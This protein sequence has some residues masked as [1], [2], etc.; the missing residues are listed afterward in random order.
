MNAPTLAIRGRLARSVYAEREDKNV[1]APDQFALGLVARVRRAGH[2]AR[3]AARCKRLARRAAGAGR[4]RCARWATNTLRA[5]AA[6]GRR[7][8]RAHAWPPRALQRGAA[9]GGRGRA[10]H[11]GHAALCQRSWSARPRC[12][13]AAW[14]RC[15]PARARP[16]RRHRRLPGRAW[17]ACRCTWSPSTTT[18]R[19]ATPTSWRR[20]SRF[21][22]LSVGVVVADLDAAGQARRP[23]PA[24]SPTAPT[25]TWSST[26]CAT[27]SPPAAAPAPAQLRARQLFDRR[28]AHAA[29]AAR[30]ALRHRRRGRQHP[31]R[32][33]AHAADP[34]RKGR[35]Q[36]RMPAR[37][38]AG[39]GTGPASSRR[40]SDYLHRRRAPRAAPDATPAA[41]RLAALCAGRGD[42]WR[43]AHAREHLL[44]QALRAL[45]L[46]QRDKQY[47]VAP[48]ARCRSS[49][50]T[51]A[52]CC[53]TAPGSRACTR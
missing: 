4:T 24:T 7:A 1:T 11:A 47:L 34:G 19:G 21:A 3:G 27:A 50:N 31:H 41:Q 12:C 52:A 33:G 22:G 44:L 9:A 29:A 40:R 38:A 51:P 2:A 10:A 5:G 14:P 6:P 36:A 32:R 39:A 26:T 13:A 45:H 35:R 42:P 48:T 46:F 53:P 16:H 15:R 43:S 20:C 17:P 18:W 8:G 49:T 30:P 25:R 28:A 37:F 23:T